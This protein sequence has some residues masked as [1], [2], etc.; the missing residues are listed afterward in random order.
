MDNLNIRKFYGNLPGRNRSD[1]ILAFANKSKT[2][3]VY[4]TQDSVMHVFF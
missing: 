4:G 3:I 1:A 2:P